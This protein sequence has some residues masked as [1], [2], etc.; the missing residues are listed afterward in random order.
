MG[1]PADGKLLIKSLAK[2][3]QYFPEEIQ[4]LEW[5]PT[6]QSL[7]FERN[8]NGLIVSLPEKTFDELSYANVIKVF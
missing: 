7:T 8:E 5:L 2:N 1:R 4:K 6:K 3:D